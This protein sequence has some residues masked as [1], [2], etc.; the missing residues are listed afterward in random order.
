LPDDCPPSSRTE[1][2]LKATDRA[3]LEVSE[4]GFTPAAPRKA[5]WQEIAHREVSKVGWEPRRTRTPPDSSQA[6]CRVRNTESGVKVCSTG[7]SWEG[8]A[9]GRRWAIVRQDSRTK[10]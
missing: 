5:H 10:V 2:S 3:L 7:L 6:P 1:A 9:T 8:E 4:L